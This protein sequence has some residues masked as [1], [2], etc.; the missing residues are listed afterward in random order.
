VRIVDRKTKV[1][2]K[3]I[4][5][6]VKKAVRKRQGKRKAKVR[7]SDLDELEKR[8]INIA[9]NESTPRMEMLGVLSEWNPELFQ[10]KRGTPSVCTL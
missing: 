2:D 7:E 1:K 5:N 8:L 10:E 6:S 3:M 4:E 9:L